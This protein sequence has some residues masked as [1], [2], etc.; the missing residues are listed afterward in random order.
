ML[1]S[2]KVIDLR[3]HLTSVAVERIREE[4]CEA[5]RERERMKLAFATTFSL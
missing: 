2:V 1:S 3:G 5:E 4:R